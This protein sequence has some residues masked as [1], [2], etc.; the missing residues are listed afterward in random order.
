MNDN[1]SGHK[2]R[3]EDY[4]CA[5]EEVLLARSALPF[6][7][8][9]AA[10]LRAQ[11]GGSLKQPPPQLLQ[12]FLQFLEQLMDFLPLFIEVS[13]KNCQ[14]LSRYEYSKILFRHEDD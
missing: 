3:R 12:G 4:R 5:L 9:S 11:L 14:I 10:A 2:L 7:G 1:S 13:T 8:S 6:L